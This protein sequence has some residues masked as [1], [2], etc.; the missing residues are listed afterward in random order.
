MMSNNRLANF[1]LILSLLLMLATVPLLAKEGDRHQPIHLEADRV[2]I[3][4]KM[5]QSRYDGNVKLRQGTLEIEAEHITVYKPGDAVERME[6]TGTPVHFRQQGDTPKGDIRG[7]ANNIQYKADQSLI[8]LDGDA[9]I[10]QE[11]DEFRGEHIVYDMEQ[12]MVDAKGAEEG[13]TRVHV[14]IQPKKQ[15]EQKESANDDTFG[16]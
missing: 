9:H 5:G 15:P 6:A 11:K 1:G 12:K 4:E 3:N 10:W 8:I 16:Q 2:M 7:Y 14:I 13:Q